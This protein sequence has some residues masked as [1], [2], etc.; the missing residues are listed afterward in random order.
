MK[1]FLSRIGIGA[2]K[3][4]TVLPNNR[5]RLGETIDARVDVQGGSSAQKIDD[6]YLAFVTRYRTEEG[7]ASGVVATTR[8]AHA[9]EIQ[10]GEKKS[11]PVSLQVPYHTPL[12][13]GHTQVWLKTGL[14]VEWAVDPS[15]SDAL[16]V[17]PDERLSALFQ[18]V[19]SLGFALRGAECKHVRS[20]FSAQFA[21]ELEFKPTGGP[22]AGRVQELEMIC[23]CSPSDVQVR[24][25]VDSRMGGLGGLLMG[26]IEQKRGFTFQSAD[27]DQLRSKLQQLLPS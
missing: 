5:C 9:F 20:G 18:A 3:V 25:E 15:D 4:D 17:E 6:V 26:E 21:Q 24:M 16:A 27:A 1:E 10:P 8:A 11:F 13:V 12:S 19:Q 14:D 2:A 22:Y 23:L 7:Y